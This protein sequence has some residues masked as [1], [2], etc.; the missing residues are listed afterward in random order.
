MLRT[1]RTY[2][3]SLAPWL[4]RWL[5]PLDD[6]PVVL[7]LMAPFAEDPSSSLGHMVQWAVDQLGVNGSTHCWCNGPDLDQLA[8]AVAGEE[9]PILLMGTARALQYLLEERLR[10]APMPLPSG[11]RI[12]ETGGFKGAARTLERDAFYIGLSQGLSVQPYAIISEYGMTELGSQGYQPGLRA[13]SDRTLARKLGSSLLDWPDGTVDDDG[14]PRVL[15]FPPW[16]RV[17]A[18][19]PDT[20]EL[21]PDG[22]RGL[23][24]FWDLSNVD[25][26]LAV[27]TADMGVV[28]PQ[29]VHLHGRSPGSTPRGCS[30][31]VDEI[32]A[33]A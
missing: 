15:V 12:M 24:R 2:E 21:L 25:S 16:C 26:V 11:S 19:D 20:L 32:L 9:R 8:D 30:L 22:E 5:V 31:A 18:T 28:L 13:L 17:G 1:G 33:R 29:G 10:D 27:Q 3:A 6:D 14:V 4:R 23:L 7:A